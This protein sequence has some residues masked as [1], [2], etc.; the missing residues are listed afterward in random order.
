[1]TV[2][3]DVE[4]KVFFPLLNNLYWV[5]RDIVAVCARWVTRVERDEERLWFARQLAREAAEIPMYRRHALAA[6]GALNPQWRIRDS[7]ARYQRLLETDDEVELVVGMH[8]LAQ[9]VLGPLE[10][11]RLYRFNPD[12]F[13]GFDDARVGNL[14]DL[15][16]AKIFLGRR[17]TARVHEHL[18][19]AYT[20]LVET[21]VPEITPLMAPLFE[22]GVIEP[23]AVAIAKSTFRELA[24]ALQ[25]E[26][27][28]IPAR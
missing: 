15:E 28:D 7:I 16:Y 8:I 27:V 13:S 14:A 11:E 22:L 9:G 23:E 10:H 20:H 4:K 26:I 25:C 19:R 12:Y 18:Q 2:L 3:T 5:H 21:T 24:R 17:P 6:G 1:M